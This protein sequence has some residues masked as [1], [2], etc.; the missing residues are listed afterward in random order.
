LLE[1]KNQYR[2]QFD[3][4]NSKGQYVFTPPNQVDSVKKTYLPSYV[5]YQLLDGDKVIYSHKECVQEPIN[6]MSDFRDRLRNFP[7]PNVVAVCWIY[8]DAVAKALS[9]LNE[10][11]SKVP[12]DIILHAL[13]KD[14][15]D[16]LRDVS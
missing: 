1:T 10:E 8:K 15:G 12:N 4:L 3:Y 14:G 6:L 13:V 16:G 9:E 11:L 7:T 2:E 5:N